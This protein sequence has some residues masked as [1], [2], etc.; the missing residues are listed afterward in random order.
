MT[1]L[2]KIAKVIYTTFVP[3]DERRAV[4]MT[5][6][7]LSDR[8]VIS[9]KHL[10]KDVVSL[11]HSDGIYLN[12]VK[13]AEELVLLHHKAGSLIK[14]C[15]QYLRQYS[16]VS[17]FKNATLSHLVSDEQRAKI[18]HDLAV[19]I[20]EKSFVKRRSIV[21]GA[22]KREVPELDTDQLSLAV[23]LVLSIK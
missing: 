14:L 21:R 8:A 15:D 3:E 18:V 19:A 10:N 22:L 17:Y 13:S 1:I 9:N 2:K 23:E 16:S 5:E 12:A 11:E 4:A 6:L 7:T 20:D